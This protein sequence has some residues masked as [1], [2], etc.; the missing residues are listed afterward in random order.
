MPNPCLKVEHI[1]DAMLREIQKRN[2]PTENI[3][4]ELRMGS[5]L[6]PFTVPGFT[7]KHIG[8]QKDT[9]FTAQNR[10]DMDLNCLHTNF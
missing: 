4:K 2:F 1:S 3:N 6:S 10:W 9:C 5:E 8:N 7:V